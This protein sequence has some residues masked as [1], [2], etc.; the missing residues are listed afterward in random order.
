MALST[1]SLSVG[2]GSGNVNVA[3][4]ASLAAVGAGD[5]TLSFWLKCSAASA[6]DTVFSSYIN[7]T[8]YRLFSFRNDTHHLNV[9]LGGLGGL[10]AATAAD[11]GAWHHWAFRRSGSIVTVWLDGVQDASSGLGSGDCSSDYG[12]TIGND[13]GGGFGDRTPTALMDDMAEWTRALSSTEIA[14]LAAGTT[15]PATLTTSLKAL[16]RFEE[17]TGT[18][19]ADSSGNGN[20]GTLSGTATWSADVPSQLAGG[21]GGVVA[22]NLSLLGVG[23]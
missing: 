11:D 20:T 22:H 16:W 5:F 9:L 17:G 19:A 12:R 13:F 2:G 15:D 21:G 10:D 14:G 6:N 23:G 18:S 4:S 8:G 1:R 3:N 7:T